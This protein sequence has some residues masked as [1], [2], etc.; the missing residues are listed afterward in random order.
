M[1]ETTRSSET[2]LL[3]Q[4]TQHHF[5]EEKILNLKNGFVEKAFELG[6]V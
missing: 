3:Y 6:L 5:P 2:V 1:T 4:N